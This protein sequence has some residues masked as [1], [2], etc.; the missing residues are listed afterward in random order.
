MNRLSFT[1]RTR[2]ATTVAAACWL[3]LSTGCVSSPEPPAQAP[4]SPVV[5][6]TSDGSRAA[7]PAEMMNR[8]ADT[9]AR[10]LATRL[11]QAVTNQPTKVVL[12]F[13][14]LTNRASLD[15]R[16]L[17]VIEERL[18]TQLTSAESIQGS[19]IV[20]AGSYDSHHDLLR[21]FQPTPTDAYDPTGT[22]GGSQ[23][24]QYDPSLLYFLRL[25]ANEAEAGNQ[26]QLNFTVRFTHPQSRRDLLAITL[27]TTLRWSRA[28]GGWIVTEQP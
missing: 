10:E 16:T 2:H 11:P 19:F 8:F 1:H 26:R 4:P 3:A 24:A 14:P 15:G 17:S 6:R 9:A 5:V 27:D 23:P 7:I 21:G 12:A 18:R 25:S 13:A 28:A 20:I 22:G